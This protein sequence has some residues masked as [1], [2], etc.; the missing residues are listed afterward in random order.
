MKTYHSV[1]QA[2]TALKKRG[3]TY[4]FNSDYKHI[5][6]PE[7]KSKFILNEFKVIQ[8]QRIEDPN[9]PN[10]NITLLV[11]QSVKYGIKGYWTNI[12]ENYSGIKALAQIPETA[13]N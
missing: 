12:S 13:N 11:I 3:F 5:C 7:G 4:D 9:D 8:I 10:E 6:Y 2:I 1:Q